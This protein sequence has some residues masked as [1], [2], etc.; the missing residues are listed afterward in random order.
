MRQPVYLLAENILSPLGATAGENL[1]QLL[2]NNT[3]IRLHDRPAFSPVPFY[4]ALMDADMAVPG[5]EPY[6]RFE[7]LLIRSVADAL[8]ISGIPAYDTDTVFIVSTTKG[9]IS[10]LEQ[11]PVDTPLKKRMTLHAAAR[12]VSEHLGFA[13]RPLVVSHAC[14]SGLVAII[15]AMRLLQSGRYRHAVV[16]GADVISRFVLS[17]FQSF[18]A[19]SDEPCRPFDAGRKGINL[20]EGAATLVLSVEKARGAVQLLGGATS[21]D[22]NHISGPSRTGAELS[23]AIASAL[24]DAGTVK[25]EIDC[26]AA[27]G[28]ATIYN[29]EMEAKAINLAGLQEIPLHSIKGYYGHTLGAAG[30]IETAVAAM[31]LRENIFLPTKGYAHSGTTQHVQVSSILQR[32]SFNTCLKMASGFG[33]CNAALILQQ[34]T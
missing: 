17:G 26:I 33:G 16:S 9:N 29:D 21:N 12:L 11:A 24:V 14:I 6:T 13:H 5:L 27:H 10:L 7:Q 18:H 3:G 32:G 2:Q 22:A 28:T 8:K 23:Q 15:T 4:A 20:G 19:V 34:S 1:E 31:S 25:E 30:L